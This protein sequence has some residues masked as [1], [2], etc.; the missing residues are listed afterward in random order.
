MTL[1]RINYYR[2]LAG[3]PTEVRF[4]DSLTSMCQQAALMMHINNELSH[5]PDASWSCYSDDGKLAAGKSNLALGVHST[6]AIALYMIDPGTNNG[7]VGHRRWILYSRAKDFGM[8]STNRAH[9]LYVINNK[10]DAPEDL[11][12]IAYPSPGYFPAPL[13]PNR[14]SISVPR[15]NFTNSTVEMVDEFGNDIDA[16]IL[17][18]KNGFGD[19]TLVWEVASSSIDRSSEFDQKIFA[20]VDKIQIGGRDTSFS[21]SVIIAPA[22]Y[23]PNCQEGTGWDESQCDCIPLQTSSE[24]K[25][26]FKVIGLSPNPAHHTVRFVLPQSMSMRQNR[27]KLV[28]LSGKVVYDYPFDDN[29]E[30]NVESLPSGFYTAMLSTEAIQYHAK[31]IIRH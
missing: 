4:D 9:A 15:A 3:L 13:L 28:D 23:P 29:G 6:E 2:R 5:E 16:D 22:S 12:Y 19:N 27:V 11:D 7:A 10:I 30:I 25:D 31:L 14:W 24:S 17:P 1:D 8:G 18:I 21:Y 20:T 26:K